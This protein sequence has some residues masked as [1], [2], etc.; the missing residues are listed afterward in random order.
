MTTAKTLLQETFAS[1]LNYEGCK[2][3][4]VYENLDASGNVILL[5]HWSSPEQYDRYLAWRKE[6]GIL[7]RFGQTFASPPNIRYFNRLN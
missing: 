1:T 6:T 4:E 5:T 7:D 3:Y 2:G